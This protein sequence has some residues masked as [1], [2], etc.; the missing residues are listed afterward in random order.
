MLHVFNRSLDSRL[1]AIELPAIIKHS[2]DDQ[3]IKLAGITLPEETSLRLRETLRQA[4]N[5]SFVK[6][7]RSVMLFGAVLAAASGIISWL[8]IAD[9][10]DRK[11]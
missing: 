11:E 5:E 2:L 4:I 3:R 1:S 6:G 10:E 7:F 8:R 9:R